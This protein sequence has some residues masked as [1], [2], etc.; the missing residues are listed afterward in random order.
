[1]NNFCLKNFLI[2]YIDNI[3]TKNNTLIFKYSI[4]N[5]F[6]IISDNEIWFTDLYDN[7]LYIFQ[8]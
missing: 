4:L 2:K 8:I 5:N 6:I 3:I 1:M 7:F